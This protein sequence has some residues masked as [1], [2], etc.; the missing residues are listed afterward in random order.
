MEVTLF[1][2]LL[3]F[4]AGLLSCVSPC[5][6]PLLP[7]YM[8]NLSGVAAGAPHPA[9][10]RRVVMGHSAAFVLGFTLVFVGFGASIGLVGYALR[11]QQDL[12]RKVGGIFMIAMGLQI[13]EI[14]RIPMLSRTFQPVSAQTGITPHRVG[15]GRSVGLGAAMAVGWTPCIGPTLGGILTLAATSG[16]TAQASGLLLAY[17]LGLAVPFLA[18]GL[19]VDQLTRLT[20]RL[21]PVMPV[22]SVLSGVILIV[23]GMLIYTNTLARFNR[24]FQVSGLGTSI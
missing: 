11:D 24:Y 3:A 4:A 2:P 18:A 15:Y 20:H 21:R 23:A 8:G 1:T 9:R 13:A 19:A 22:I 17:S 5:V 16:A 14:I 12:L 7:A 10:P 6:L